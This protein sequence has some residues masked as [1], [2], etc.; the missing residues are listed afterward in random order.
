MDIQYNRSEGYRTVVKHDVMDGEQIDSEQNMLDLE[1]DSEI[2]TTVVFLPNVW[3]LMPTN[4]EYQKIVEAYKNFID[5][6]PAEEVEETVETKPAS[7]KSEETTNANQSASAPAESA[8]TQVTPGETNETGDQQ[9]TDS[10]TKA[11][12]FHSF[13]LVLYLK[14]LIPVKKAN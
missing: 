9:N 14:F 11:L 4:I 13:F 6:P 1:E 5:N 12:N 8:N 2:E 7:V 10:K 3:S